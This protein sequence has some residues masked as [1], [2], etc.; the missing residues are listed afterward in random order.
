[1]MIP[2]LLNIFFTAMVSMMTRVAQL[3]E[4]PLTMLSLLL[5]TEMMP[6][7]ERT[8]GSSATRGDPAGVNPD[9]SA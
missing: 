2:D 5:A 8:T 6:P 4:R 3:M 9:T 1:M 7:P